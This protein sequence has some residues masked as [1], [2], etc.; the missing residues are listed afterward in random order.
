[1]NI[2]Q[3][4]LKISSLILIVVALVVSGVYFVAK[5]K[6]ASP[7]VTLQNDITNWKTF[8][9]DFYPYVMEFQYPEICSVQTYPHNSP[10]DIKISCNKPKIHI[11]ISTIPLIQ[12]EDFKESVS[13]FAPIDK[14]YEHITSEQYTTLANKKALKIT[15]QSWDKAYEGIWIYVQAPKRLAMSSSKN[16]DNLVKFS[17]ETKI[18]GTSLS[19]DGF[20]LIN[21]I[22]SIL[23]LP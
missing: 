4:F 10:E 15:Y 17:Y 2:N 5:K 7:I 19:S 21:K 22:F 6:T 20:D 1:M 14:N 16:S 18:A 9:N 11:G 13:L 12:S 3:K 8:R 23:I